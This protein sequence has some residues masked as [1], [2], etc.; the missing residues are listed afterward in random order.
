MASD[1]HA[2]FRGKSQP[3]PALGLASGPC[4]PVGSNGEG[5]SPWDSAGVGC[6]SVILGPADNQMVKQEKRGLG[7]FLLLL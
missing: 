6:P 1:I 3:V 4:A 7:P 2:P 5:V